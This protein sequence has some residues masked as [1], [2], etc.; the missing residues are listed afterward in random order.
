GG[1]KSSADMDAARA[2]AD[3]VRAM[4]PPGAHV[5][6][7]APDR[8]TPLTYSVE[9]AGD[10][11]HTSERLAAIVSVLS[12]GEEKWVLELGI[13]DST[14]PGTTYSSIEVSS[15]RVPVLD[16]ILRAHE[17]LYARLPERTIILDAVECDYTISDVPREAA[18]SAART[19]G[20]WFR[21]VLASGS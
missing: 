16:Q 19:A 6:V 21:T 9:V 1:G 20:E 8:H 18:V 15:Q 14:D 3:T 5:E 12:A 7:E 13:K 17:H 10:R 11:A 2:R 4:F